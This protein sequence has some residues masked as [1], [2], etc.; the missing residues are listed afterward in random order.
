MCKCVIRLASETVFAAQIDGDKNNSLF[1]D[2]F[3]CNDEMHM[4][5]KV[6]LLPAADRFYQY[7][8]VR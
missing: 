7:E 1:C 6:K 4:N 8:H 5:A 2:T 3:I